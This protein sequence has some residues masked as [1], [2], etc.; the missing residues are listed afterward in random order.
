MNQFLQLL[1]LI[2]LK[3]K[4]TQFKPVKISSKTDLVSDPAWVEGYGKYIYQFLKA[5][6]N[7][8]I[9]S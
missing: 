8:M 9:L 4:K 1:Y 5:I 2:S 3:M 6:L 7:T